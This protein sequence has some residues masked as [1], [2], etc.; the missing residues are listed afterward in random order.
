MK[1]LNFYFD[2][3]SPF[4]YLGAT[5]IF[6]LADQNN[7]SVVHKPFLLGALFKAI[8]T[9]MVPLHSFNAPKQRYYQRD[10]ELWAQHWGVPLL[11]PSAFPINTVGPLRLTLVA[12]AEAP[13]RVTPLVLRIFSAFWAEDQDIS[14]PEVLASL[15]SELEL[16][17]TW[18][19]KISTPEV[20]AELRDR[21]SEAVEKGVCGAPSFEVN[22]ELFWG[23]D[24][25]DFVRNALSA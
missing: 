17:V 8:G 20:K 1:S 10:L 9:P 16:P 5:E 13:E 25:L 21:T 22:G 3:S 23:Q 11:Q 24:R 7:A 19:E 14:R 15:L 18:L 6:K 4:A 12:L 2:Y